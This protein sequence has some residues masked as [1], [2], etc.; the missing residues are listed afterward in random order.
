MCSM[1]FIAILRIIVANIA[2]SKPKTNWT[3]APLVTVD[4]YAWLI[5]DKSNEP[6]ITNNAKKK[7][8]I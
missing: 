4:W 3:E 2:Y 7:I 5:N 1:Y 6:S 8:K